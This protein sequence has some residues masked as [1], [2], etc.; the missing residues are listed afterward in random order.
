MKR[1][2][3]GAG[4]RD[5]LKNL[6]IYLFGILLLSIAIAVGMGLIGRQV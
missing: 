2:R 4:V 6:V 5:T 1:K 3:R